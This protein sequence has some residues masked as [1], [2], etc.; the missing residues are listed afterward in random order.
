MGNI[1]VIDVLS[2][3]CFFAME[4]AFSSTKQ[5][6]GYLLLKMG[7]CCEVHFGQ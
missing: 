6:N 1:Y 7:I 4:R 2:E 5:K 3:I